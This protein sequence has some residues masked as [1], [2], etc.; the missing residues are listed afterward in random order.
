MIGALT[1]GLGRLGD[2]GL[3]APLLAVAVGLLLPSLAGIGYALLIPSVILMFAISVAIVE[4]GR[5]QWLEVWPAFGLAVCNLLLAPLLVHALA[6]G[7]GL[8][9]VGGWI[10]LVAACPVAGA[11]TLV[12]GLLGLAMRPMLQAQLLCFF[13]LPVT[14]PLV[15]AVMLDDLVVDPVILFWRVVLMVALPSLVGLGLRQFLRGE[16]RGFALRPIRGVGTLG[17]CGIGL[18]LAHGLSSKLG[19]DIPWASSI[20]GLGIASLVGGMLGGAIGALSGRLGGAQLGASFM[21]G[22]ALRNASLLWSATMGLTSPG[23]EAV[24]MLGTLWAYLLP[25]LLGLY[26]WRPALFRRAVALTPG[27]PL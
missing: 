25:A 2:F 24:M 22:G 18:A 9:E 5:L 27:R 11:A 16:R 12:S 6:L 7:M 26:Q 15:A 20:L 10:V 23:G 17:L 8:N 14:A 13:A 19:A 1:R 21:L 3:F 4:Q